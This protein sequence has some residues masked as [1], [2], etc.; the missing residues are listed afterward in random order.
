MG[1]KVY[2]KAAVSSIGFKNGARA[3]GTIESTLLK[4]LHMQL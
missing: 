4:Y 1:R 2:V 3:R